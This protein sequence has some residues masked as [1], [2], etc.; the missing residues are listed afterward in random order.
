MRILNMLVI[1]I[2]IVS[3]ARIATAQT[4]ASEINM[5]FIESSNVPIP[6]VGSTKIDP[7]KVKF[8]AQYACS[9]R[10]GASSDGK[11]I[12]LDVMG[13]VSKDVDLTDDAISR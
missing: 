6:A 9:V 11:T 5:G 10:Y 7:T 12:K 1:T 2:V 4:Y 3:L 13:I 8:L